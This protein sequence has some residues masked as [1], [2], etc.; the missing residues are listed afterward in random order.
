MKEINDANVTSL[1]RNP[2]EWMRWVPAVLLALAFLYLLLIGGRI[3]LVPMLA[4]VSLAYVL[5][6]VVKWFERR[7]WT[8][9]SAALLAMTTGALVIIL[10]LIFVLPGLWRQLHYSY[11]QA[12]M[13]LSDHARLE[14][15]LGKISQ[16]NPQL[17][18]VLRDQVHRLGSAA[19]QQRLYS[20]VAGWLSS[21]LF[22]LVDL[23]TSVLDL[24]LIPFFVFYLLADF[25]GMRERV[26]RLIP[27]RFRG[28]TS[29][30]LSQVNNVLSS[31]VRNQLLIGLMMGA[32]YVIGLGVLR[33]PMAFT[34]GM[35][36]GLLNFVPYLGTLIGLGLSL[37]FVALE[38][39]GLWHIIGV[40]VVFSLVQGIEGYYLT[41]KLLGSRLHLHPM[42][43]LIGLMIG[44][45]LFGLLGI[46][47]AMPV[48]AI[49]K[50]LFNFLEELY[51]QSDFYN[52][53]GL[54][55][56]TEQGHPINQTPSGLIVEPSFSDRPRRT[57]ITTGEIKSRLRDGKLSSDEEKLQLG[58]HHS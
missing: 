33:V 11:A 14:M 4:A 34:L 50:V 36:A 40:L 37:L 27:L 54:N 1:P 38:G 17:Y 8:R 16:L 55:L 19:E 10:A 24:L 18:E 46:I 6:P 52:R 15:L 21:G 30:L 41:P 23:T 56:L 32:L 35:V 45:S 2:I 12:Q 44:A 29:G 42:G 20:F 58:D 9:S 3:V 53:A 49:A 26:D 7:G 48:I 57:I 39:A 28:I 47:L 22:R 31:Y 43:V 51:Q 5:A 25:R 13:L